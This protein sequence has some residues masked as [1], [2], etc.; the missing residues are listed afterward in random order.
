MVNMSQ[1]CKK[2]FKATV[3]SSFKVLGNGKLKNTPQVRFYHIGSSLAA[4]ISFNLAD[5]GEGIKEVVVKEWFVKE[6][7]TVKQFD[8][9]C[10]VQSDKA[11]VTITSRYDGVIAKLH[12]KIDDV[13]LVGKP[14]VDIEADQDDGPETQPEPQPKPE[15]KPEIPVKEVPLQPQPKQEAVE[16]IS[17]RREQGPVS[18]TTNEVVNS[19]NGVLC[20]PAVRRLAKEHNLDLTKIKGTGR[21]GRILKED[22]L[23]YLESLEAPPPPVQ[24]LA[25]TTSPSRVQ[26]V[27]SDTDRVEPIKGFQKAMVKTMTESLNIPHFVYA[28]ELKITRLSELRKILKAS[29]NQSISFMPFLIKAVSNALQRYPVL[30]SSIDDRCENVIYHAR[31]NIGVAM[32]TKVGLAV[33]VIKDVQNLGILEINEEL[34]RLIQ[35]GKQ[36]VFKPSDLAGGTFA[37]SNIGSIGG[38]YMKPVILPPQVAIIAIGTSQLLP[39]YDENRNIV[40]EEIANISVAAD[41]RVID[42]ATVANFVK[43]LKKQ[44]ENPYLLFLNI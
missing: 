32:D 19:N 10:E 44:V 37:V 38:T 41:H 11:S 20:I 35:S 13:A 8:D 40:P 28:D 15:S 43:I 12:Y 30:N 4:R 1:T 23:N 25:P 39:R 27:P 42:G 31:H 36:G 21:D 34:K 14:L 18:S 16:K 22:V 24:K 3:F 2:V 5:I 26:S 33:P 9:I 7:D 29:H 6:G 17:I